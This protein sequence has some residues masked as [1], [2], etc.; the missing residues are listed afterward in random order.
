MHAATP[1]LDEQGAWQGQADTA[2][3]AD[4]AAASAFSGRR[5]TETG[6]P[7]PADVAADSFPRPY[8]AVTPASAG[9]TVATTTA[10]ATK[11]KTR[12]LTR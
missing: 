1:R 8:T 2:A 12:T 9:K 7:H 3:A 4:A 11:T 5:T 10:V 6:Q